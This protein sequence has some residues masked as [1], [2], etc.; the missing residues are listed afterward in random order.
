MMRALPNRTIIQG[1]LL[2]T[3]LADSRAT[4][5]PCFRGPH[6]DGIS[7]ETSFRTNW[8][9]GL[10]KL[11]ERDLGPAFSSFAVVGDRLYTCGTKDKMQVIYCL[12]ADSG[13][14]VWQDAFEAEMTDPDPELFGTRATPT[15]DDGRVYILGGIGRLVCYDAGSGKK[16]WDRKFE[17]MPQW[18]FS[19]SVLIE[20]DHAIVS[21]GGDAGSLCALNKTTGDFVWK[22]GTD[23]PGYAT[24]YPFTFKERRYVCTFLYGSIMIADARTGAKVWELEWPSHSGVNAAS[25]IF[26]DGKLF[27]SSGYGFGCGVFKLSQA[28][29]GMLSG[30]QMWKSKALKNKFQT[31]VLYKGNLFTSDEQMLKCVDFDTGDLKWRKGESLFGRMKHGTTL[32]ADGYL[33]VLSESGELQLAR[34]SRDGYKPIAK[35]KLFDGRCWTVPVLINGRLYIRSHTKA[36]CYDMKR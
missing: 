24:P 36:A 14:V 27:V 12:D 6:Y 2:L 28:K 25:P 11:W 32:I 34:A 29:N 19:G 35:Q 15:C 16:I 31:P 33:F 9:G 18:G 17:P 10:K 8:T 21:G 3:V 23:R 20:G 26:H 7:P 13:A 30:K 1:L 22:C 5:W 4:D